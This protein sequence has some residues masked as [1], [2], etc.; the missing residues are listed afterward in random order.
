MGHFVRLCLQPSE[1]EISQVLQLRS[2]LVVREHCSGWL[3]QH[4][5]EWRQNTQKV[6]LAIKYRTIDEDGHVLGGP[7]YYIENGM[8]KKWKWLAKIFAFFG[9]G[10]GLFGI[11]TFTQVNSIASAVK[12]F[13]DPD[14]RTYSIPCLEEIIPGQL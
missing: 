12:N 10:V 9:A 8:G 14:M 6:L 1:P 4:F 3:S 11:G 13:F 7:F 5:S 2:Q